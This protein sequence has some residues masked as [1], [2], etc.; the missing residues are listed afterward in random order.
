LH[1]E[2]LDADG[3]P[4]APFTLENSVPIKADSTKQRLAWKGAGDL[5]V[6]A[7]KPVRFRFHLT[8]GSLYAFWVSPRESGA[9][10]GYVAAGGPGL[11]API[12][13]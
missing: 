13:H 8:G 4:I 7:G 5:S 2:I 10:Q 6:I 3:K 12:D 11:H 1:T 9:S